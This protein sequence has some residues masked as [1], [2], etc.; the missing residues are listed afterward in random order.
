MHINYKY[1]IIQLR[2]TCTMHILLV[3]WLLNV[4]LQKELLSQQSTFWNRIWNLIFNIH[5]PLNEISF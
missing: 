1:N 2:K 4:I 5:M 3:T